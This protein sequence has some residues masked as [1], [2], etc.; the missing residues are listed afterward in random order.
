MKNVLKI[1]E[2]FYITL[3]NLLTIKAITIIAFISII[4]LTIFLNKQ[5]CNDEHPEFKYVNFVLTFNLFFLSEF[6][7]L[8]FNNYEIRPSFVYSFSSN[9]LICALY[10]LIDQKIIEFNKEL[11]LAD[12]CC[13]GFELVSSALR[14]F[15]V[16]CKWLE[17]LLYYLLFSGLIKCIF[18][19]IIYYKNP[20]ANI[21]SILI[22]N[23]TF[24][25]FYFSLS[26]NY[27]LLSNSVNSYYHYKLYSSNIYDELKYHYS[28]S[29][30]VDKIISNDSDYIK[31]RKKYLEKKN[32]FYTRPDNILS[33]FLDLFVKDST[34]ENSLSH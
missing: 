13:C 2:Y 5:F 25:I 21:L 9:Y 12:E 7:Y 14:S 22:T 29:D 8:I 34:T 10:F 18:F 3:N 32:K 33:N 28:I 30:D 15:I 27:N 6:L 16:N 20:K 11:I 17:Y 4:S 26:G 23:I 1:K 24:I 31:W 19:K